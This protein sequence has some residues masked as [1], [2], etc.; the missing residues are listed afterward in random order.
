M[1]AI[2][3]RHDAARAHQTGPPPQQPDQGLHVELDAERLPGGQL[4][5][6]LSLDAEPMYQ[7][8]NDWNHGTALPSEGAAAA[9]GSEAAQGSEA[10]PNGLIT[11]GSKRAHVS[12]KTNPTVVLRP[13]PTKLVRPRLVN[14]ARPPV[15]NLSEG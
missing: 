13:G 1:I 5:C 9:E 8:Y 12:P 7:R 10:A 3:S 6:T 2:F 14:R 11:L 15:G 4:R